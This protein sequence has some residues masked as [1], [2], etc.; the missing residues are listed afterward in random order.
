[1]RL[2]ETF[3]SKARRDARFNELTARGFKVRRSSMRNQ[4]LHPQYVTDYDGPEKLQTGFG[5]GAYRTFFPVLYL[6]T[7]E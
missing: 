6:L 7:Q 4:Q 3:Q 5:N 1:M 2:S